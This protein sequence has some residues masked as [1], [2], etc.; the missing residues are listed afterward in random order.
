MNKNPKL[1]IVGIGRWGKNIL[2]SLI[3]LGFNV[4]I[5]FSTGN[6]ENMEWLENNHPKVKFAE[7]YS[8]ILNN[9]EID[10]VVIATPI[11]THYELTKQAL[12]AGKHVF[13]EKPGTQSVESMKELCD[14]AKAKN[15]ILC[16][17]YI[18]VHHPV[19]QCIQTKLT[20]DSIASI[21]FEWNKWGSFGEDIVEN[22]LSHDLSILCALGI[23]IATS[24][25]LK[26]EN[27]VN[28]QGVSREGIKITSNI[29]RLSSEKRKVITITT[30]AGEFYIWIN[31]ELKLGASPYKEQ[32]TTV[33]IATTPA[34]DLELDNFVKS[35]S[36]ETSVL[37]DGNF[38]AEVLKSLSS[39]QAPKLS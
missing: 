31:N 32:P 25:I 2:N 24:S 22:L 23:E 34:L 12:E 4:P 9:P 29:N 26:S 21:S 37:I 28:L 13:L 27:T 7:S 36:R 17:G 1:A 33:E 39:L 11:K 6:K 30:K 10:A 14:I 16:V 38:A 18:F 20:L 15:L 5:C 8:S 35:L 3:K 19:F